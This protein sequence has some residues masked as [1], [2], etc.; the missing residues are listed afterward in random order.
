MHDFAEAAL[1]TVEPFTI[2]VYGDWGAGRP[3]CSTT[4]IVC[5]MQERENGGIAPTPVFFP[6]C[7]RPAALGW[8]VCLDAFLR[9]GRGGGA[10]ALPFSSAFKASR[11]SFGEG[12][13]EAAAH[14]FSCGRKRGPI[15]VPQLWALTE[16]CVLDSRARD[17]KAKDMARWVKNP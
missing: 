6:P 15:L 7:H 14:W 17:S 10:P 2:G 1:G 3:A 11:Q 16:L 9:R 12:A 4:L 5:L 13:P 8:S